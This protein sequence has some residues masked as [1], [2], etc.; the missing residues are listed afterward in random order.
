MKVGF[1]VCVHS[2]PIGLHVLCP[3][4]FF[5]AFTCFDHTHHSDFGSLT[6]LT[7]PWLCPCMRNPS[8]FITPIINS[9]DYMNRGHV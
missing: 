9:S 4:D 8:W 6:A 7:N 2:H 1:C 5:I 3:A